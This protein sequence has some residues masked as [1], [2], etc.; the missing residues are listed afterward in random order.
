MLLKLNDKTTEALCTVQM[1]F[2]VSVEC[3]CINAQTIA[4]F[5]QQKQKFSLFFVLIFLHSKPDFIATTRLPPFL[6]PSMHKF[7]HY[8]FVNLI[9]FSIKLHELFVEVQ[10]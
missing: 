10:F 4:I 8:N 2:A 1:Q 9:Y 5:R 3:A 6:T 7:S